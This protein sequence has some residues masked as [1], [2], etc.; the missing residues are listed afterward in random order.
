MT[1][2]RKQNH[3]LPDCQWHNP[4]AACRSGVSSVS[5][6][7]IQH[8]FVGRLILE[9]GS[10]QERT[11]NIADS[12][13]RHLLVFVLLTAAL[14]AGRKLRRIFLRAKTDKRMRTAGKVIPQARRAE[15]NLWQPG[16]M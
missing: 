11:L 1:D 14:L 16:A 5:A 7:Y 3:I 10:E 9:D 2:H 8:K 12:P 6:Q 4:T 13:L 15:K